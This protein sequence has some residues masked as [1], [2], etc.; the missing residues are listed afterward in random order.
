[1]DCLIQGGGAA[2]YHSSLDLHEGCT[3]VVLAFLRRGQH[4]K[5]VTAADT[6]ESS[7]KL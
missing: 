7:E 6:M 1:M 2:A 5:R 3:F 4:L